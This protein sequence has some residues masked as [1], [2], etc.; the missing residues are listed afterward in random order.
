MQLNRDAVHAVLLHLG[1][2]DFIS[3][4]NIQTTAKLKPKNAYI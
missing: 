4:P 2:S 1:E 3:K